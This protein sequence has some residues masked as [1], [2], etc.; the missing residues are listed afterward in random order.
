ML[1]NIKLSIFEDIINKD[2]INSGMDT[3]I[4]PQQLCVFTKFDKDEIR[5]NNSS[6]LNE[7]IIPLNSK[8][9]SKNSGRS[10]KYKP[11]IGSCLTSGFDKYKHSILEEIYSLDDLFKS[12][13]YLYDNK[14]LTKNDLKILTLRRH[15]QK[16]INIPLNKQPIKFNVI[17]WKKL[18]FFTYD[19]EENEKELEFDQKDSTQQLLH[20]SGFKFEQII[21]NQDLRSTNFFSVSQ[22]KI[23]KIPVLYSAEIDCGIK[24]DDSNFENYVELKT[25]SNYNP[26]TLNKFHKKLMSLYCQNKFISCNH[27]IIGFRQDFKLCSIKK[28]TNYELIGI[29]ESNPIF[30]SD[31]CFINTKHIFTWYNIVMNWIAEKENEIDKDELV[32]L[33]LSFDSETELMDSNLNFHKVN[34]KESNKIFNKVIP[35][36]FK[37]FIESKLCTNPS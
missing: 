13:K 28:Y 1:E 21:T 33:K 23:N 12:I 36:W 3:T 32:V 29:L 27:S 37:E 20:Y 8:K 25:H 30:L 7:L 35:P 9:K 10:K 19:W 15:L 34:E 14:Q 6:G 5:F 2:E 18:I 24:K 22:H 17:Y 11:I 16:L 4:N 26:K 31:K